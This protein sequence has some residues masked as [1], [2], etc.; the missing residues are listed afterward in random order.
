MRPATRSNEVR[1]P[2]G[3]TLL[4]MLV[5]VAL[6][7]LMMTILASIFQAATGAMSASRT[8]QELDDSLRLLDMTIRQDLAGVTARMTPPLDP[9]M[10]L[11]Y[12]EYGENAP[13]DLQGEDTD[14]YIAFTTKAPEGQFFTG[15]VYYTPTINLITNKP[16]LGALPAT[17]TS[18]FAEVIYYLRHGNLY[19]RVLL[20]R[21]ELK[22][23]LTV[24]GGVVGRSG[25][26]APSLSNG[27]NIS[28]MGVNDISARPSDTPSIAN[29]IDL[30]PVPNDLGDLTNRENRFARPRFADDYVDHLLGKAPR[31][32]IADDGNGDGIPDYWPTLTWNQVNLATSSNQIVAGSAPPNGQLMNEDKTTTPGAIGGGYARLTATAD[33]FAFPFMY[34]GMYSKPETS[35]LDTNN[36]AHPVGW[37][38]ALDTTLSG[39]TLS[40]STNTGGVYLNHAPLEFGDSLPTPNSV[41]PTPT[42][43]LTTW[44]GFPTWRE[45]ASVNWAD[46]VFG[47]SAPKGWT[48]GQQPPGL[49]FLDPTNAPSL[50]NGNFLPPI[51]SMPPLGFPTPLLTAGVSPPPS[52]P[53]PPAVITPFDSDG[54]GS[55][56]GGGF[57]TTQ[58]TPP[59]T[60][61]FLN[62]TVLWDDDLIMTGVRSFDVKAFDYNASVYNYANFFAQNTAPPANAPFYTPGYYD[63]GY[64][65]SDYNALLGSTLLIN[66]TTPVF[67]DSGNLNALFDA[68]FNPQGFG[69]EG[70]MPPNT[71]DFRVD[72]QRPYNNNPATANFGNVNF[73]G[74]N[75]T[76]QPRMRRVWD[77]WS[78]T[79][80]QAPAVDVNL[81]G[82]TLQPWP[83]DRPMYPSYPPPYPQ[84]LRGIQ[85]Q[86][87]V[88]D[89]KS[90]RVKILTIRQDFS[91]KL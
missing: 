72:P 61:T 14:D 2:R 82:S 81:R 28:W 7:V 62:P 70:R 77:T 32:G 45:T 69:H 43:L 13:A 37:L 54:A 30:T 15:R 85:I 55:L 3:F 4:E 25:I 11:G 89:A 59:A 47:Q 71:K 48:I 38:H 12:F 40:L 87:R 17:V 65:A 74:D 91:D 79:Y 84:P 56:V 42:N 75:T 86:I 50:T 33:V 76:G 6:V 64:A 1:R 51:G 21:P 73:V 66:G 58:L 24:N 68:N 27:V 78:T 23:Q 46:P 90:E 22:G 35:S 19:R 53:F 36:S 26:F 39:G 9:A 31:D 20:I 10:K 29:S 16:N 88:S 80:T 8:Y 57:T 49:Q 60:K 18:K 5:V 52:Y 44:W 41:I 67:T 63:L 34:P 83:L